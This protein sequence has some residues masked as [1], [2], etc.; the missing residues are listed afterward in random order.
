M[1]QQPMEA[2]QSLSR[3]SPGQLMRTPLQ[4]SLATAGLWQMFA[5][6]SDFPV[7]SAGVASLHVL[8]GVQTDATCLLRRWC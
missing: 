1:C 8:L 6:V 7:Q 2:A 3:T 5:L 4:N